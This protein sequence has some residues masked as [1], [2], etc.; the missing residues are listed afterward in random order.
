MT[1]TNLSN[2]VMIVKK[3]DVDGNSSIVQQSNTEDVSNY[4]VKPEVTFSNM[5]DS[6]ILVIASRKPI[7]EKSLLDFNKAVIQII[8]YSIEDLPKSY[9]RLSETLLNYWRHEARRDSDFDRSFSY[10]R[11]YQISSTLEVY[12]TEQKHEE[13]I[14][15]ELEE[16]QSSRELLGYIYQHPGSTTA[17]LRAGMDIS[18]EKLEDTIHQLEM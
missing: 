14:R 1:A 16:H 3:L 9:Y 12:R 8:S 11:A 5:C 7:R 15:S 17:E 18:D 10:V 13:I 2:G 6:L 4:S